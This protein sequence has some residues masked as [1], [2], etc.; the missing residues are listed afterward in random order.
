MNIDFTF[1]NFE[2]SEHLKKY[3]RRRFEK[4]LKYFDNEENAQLQV[5]MAVDKFRHQT[6]V[7]L[8]VDTMRITANEASDD[9]Y[10]S[11]DL[12]LDKLDAQVRKLREKTKDHRR[13]GKQKTAQTEIITFSMAEDGSRERTI[14]ARDHYEPKPMNVDEAAEQLDNRNYEF[15][16]FRN[17]ETDRVNVIYRRKNND[18][19]L[20]DPGT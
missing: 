4:I 13:G 17:A 2:P 19:G 14:T 18:F 16:V 5:N 1:K 7:L 10:T 6:E 12:V 3:A 15:L 20:I 11:L 9:M 8:S